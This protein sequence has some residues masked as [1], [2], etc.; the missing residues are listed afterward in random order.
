M[1]KMEDGQMSGYFC[2]N[3]EWSWSKMLIR[4]SRLGKSTE[5]GGEEIRRCKGSL[6][7]EATGRGIC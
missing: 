7:T 4:K 1:E 3:G 6:S 2:P 5:W